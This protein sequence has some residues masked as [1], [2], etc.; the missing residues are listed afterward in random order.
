[1]CQPE[2][3]WMSGNTRQPVMLPGTFTWYYYHQVLTCVGAINPRYQLTVTE[4]GSTVSY[5]W[6][7]TGLGL[8]GWGGVS[9]RAP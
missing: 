3:I 7:W 6:D 5:K 9:Y 1:M 4:G 2:N 8:D